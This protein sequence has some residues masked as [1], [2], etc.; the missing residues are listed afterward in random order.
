VNPGNG[1][2]PMSHPLHMHGQRFLVIVRDGVRT[3]NLVWKDTTVIPV[4]STVDLLVDMSNP[5]NWMLNCQI[6]E[7][8]GSGMAMTFTVDPAP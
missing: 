2:H 6:P 8:M 1:V 5:G 3:T 7:H 4:G